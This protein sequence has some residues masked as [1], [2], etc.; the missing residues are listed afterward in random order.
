MPFEPISAAKWKPQAAI[1]AARPQRALAD[2]R[3]RQQRQRGQQ[4]CDQSQRQFR[5]QDRRPAE[6]GRVAV[7]HLAPDQVHADAASFHA[8]ADGIGQAPQIGARQQPVF[9]GEGDAGAPVRQLEFIDLGG[10]RT[11]EG[12][13]AVGRGMELQAVHRPQHAHGEQACG[14]QLRATTQRFAPAAAP[15]P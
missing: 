11:V 7:I 10:E 12:I 1:T 8:G 6:P 4:Q 14:R 2:S 3:A 9:V 13:A 15:A 5:G